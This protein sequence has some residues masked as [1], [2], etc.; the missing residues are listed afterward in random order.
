[1]VIGLLG[2]N[3]A[4]YKFVVFMLK[5]DNNVCSMQ[6]HALSSLI[7]IE[8]HATR[9]HCAHYFSHMPCWS[10]ALLQLPSSFNCADAVVMHGLILNVIHRSICIT[11]C[12]T[13]TSIYYTIL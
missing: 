11:L 2:N 4:L 5:L 1:M 7:I 10:I 8:R 6:E 3:I 13:R 9:A 12:T